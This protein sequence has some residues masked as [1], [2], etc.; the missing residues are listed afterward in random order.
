MSG[1][2]AQVMLDLMPEALGQLMQV[3]A[4]MPG[5]G[6]G[7]TP[8]IASY[9]IGEVE[10]D[11]EGELFR[12][13]FTSDAGGRATLAVRWKLVLGQWKIAQITLVS[14]EAPPGEGEAPSAAGS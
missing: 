10:D 7:A 2:L 6:M 11:G 5:G 9:E 3:G 13:T 4:A 12:T 1:N 14:M 8:T